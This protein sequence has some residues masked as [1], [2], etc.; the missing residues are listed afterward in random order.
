[1]LWPILLVTGTTQIVLAVNAAV[2]F[3]ES[4]VHLQLLKNNLTSE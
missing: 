4:V 3:I 2:C 1:M